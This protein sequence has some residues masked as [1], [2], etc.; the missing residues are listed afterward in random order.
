MHLWLH[1]C[2]GIPGENGNVP[3]KY[4]LTTKTPAG[5]EL[6]PADQQTLEDASVQVNNGQTIM[7]FTK[8][9]DEAGEI[10]IKTGDNNFL[11]AYGSSSTLGYHANR[12]S[13]V[14]NLSTGI[15]AVATTSSVNK[16]ALL[17]R[18]VDNDLD[19][20]HTLNDAMTNYRCFDI[21]L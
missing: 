7:T 16:S 14:Q 9:M 5:T 20:I 1:R 8:M 18:Y 15:S 4:N 11:W 2:S 3:Q 12:G 13:Y 17:A 19:F 10:P 21:D 6:M